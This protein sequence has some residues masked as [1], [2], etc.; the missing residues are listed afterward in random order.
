MGDIR[1]CGNGW[2]LCEAGESCW[3]CTKNTQGAATT[4][5]TPTTWYCR[6]TGFECEFATVYGYC[7]LTACA[8]VVSNEKR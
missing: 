5:T 2:Q 1:W 6:S 7:K 4:A 8:K 3:T